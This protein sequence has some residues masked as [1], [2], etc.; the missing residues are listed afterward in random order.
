VCGRND[1]RVGLKG[2]GTSHSREVCSG[3]RN[4]G[5]E[6]VA[7]EMVNDGENGNG[8]ETAG[9][10]GADERPSKQTKLLD[11]P[12]KSSSGVSSCSSDMKKLV[13]K[14]PVKKKAQKKGLDSGTDVTWLAIGTPLRLHD[15][16][17]LV[18]VFGFD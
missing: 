12:V 15:L 11:N 13:K 9:E 3:D 2:S 5:G 1:K 10:E 16:S 18:V 17:Q 4:S 14:K 6:V 8:G 7:G